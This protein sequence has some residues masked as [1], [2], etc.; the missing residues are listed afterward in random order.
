V[1]PTLIFL[2]TAFELSNT[3]FLSHVT[4]VPSQNDRRRHI[5]LTLNDRDIVISSLLIGKSRHLLA[6]DSPAQHLLAYARPS[7]C[8]P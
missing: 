7:T 8:I 5:F 4:D 1:A 3:T 6:D 2:Q